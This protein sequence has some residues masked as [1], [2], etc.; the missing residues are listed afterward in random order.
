[1]LGNKPSLNKH[2][3]IKII[4][5]ILSDHNALKME[6]NHILKSRKNK[7]LGIKQHATKETLGHKRNKRRDQEIHRNE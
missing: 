1:M 5:S 2:K 6:I 7:Y 4:P 3:R